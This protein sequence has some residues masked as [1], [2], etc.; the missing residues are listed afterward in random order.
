M[1]VPDTLQIKPVA[2]SASRTASAAAAVDEEISYS[3]HPLHQPTASDTAP[4]L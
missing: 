3:V 1:R 2:A 4:C